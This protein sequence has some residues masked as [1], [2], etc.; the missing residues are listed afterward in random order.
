MRDLEAILR[1]I[2]GRGYKAYKELQGQSFEI[3]GWTLRFDHV[4]G[5]PYAAPSRL[6]A[7]V[8]LDRAALP[9]AAR[10]THRRYPASL[11]RAR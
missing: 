2:D 1:R 10:A 3:E 4:Q 6:R 9:A 5:D 8:A 7:F 11:R